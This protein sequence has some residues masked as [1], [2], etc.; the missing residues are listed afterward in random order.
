MGLHFR[1]HLHMPGIVKSLG[2]IVSSAGHIV[3]DVGHVIGKVP[4]LGVALNA[5][6]LAVPG[7]DIAAAAFDAVKVASAVG[8]HAVAVSPIVAAAHNALPPAQ[9]QGFQ[10]AIGA[11]S[12]ADVTPK[13]LVALRNTLPP[14]DQ[15]GFD[16]AT[17]LQTGGVHGARPPAN[18]PPDQVAGWYI[19]HGATRGMPGT[20]VDT[21]LAVAA[22]P[23]L[24]Q[25]AGLAAADLN[26]KH[27]SW[28]HRAL[29]TVG[30]A[31]DAAPSAD[32]AAAAPPQA[33]AAGAAIG[34]AQAQA[35]AAATPDPGPG[36][37]PPAG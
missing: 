30:L 17:A 18:L 13:Q 21:L 29:V 12:Q 20:Q 35:A 27:N 6:A 5:I 31:H 4:G 16:V 23:G 3:G 15:K 14:E 8:R 10:A 24:N 37:P 7:A 2:H 25:G 26:R 34:D 32:M 28:W 19:A 33:N 9:Q 11:L 1:I 22:M 36:A